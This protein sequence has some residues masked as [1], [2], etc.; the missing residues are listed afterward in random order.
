MSETNH[1]ETFKCPACGA[2][3]EYKTPGARTVKCAFC[4]SP[5]AVPEYLLAA[6]APASSAAAGISATDLA[7]IVKALQKNNKL[8]AIKVYRRVTNA[9][10]EVARQAIAQI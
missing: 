4:G 5:A 10:L 2:A 8:E 7:Q 1:V 9:S 3:I 6:G